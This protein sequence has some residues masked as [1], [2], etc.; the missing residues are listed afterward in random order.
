M[1]YIAT[2]RIVLKSGEIRMHRLLEITGRDKCRGKVNI[3]VDEVGFQLHRMSADETHS[4][5][6]LRLRLPVIV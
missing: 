6:L 1:T 4:K 5:D 3:A 2:D